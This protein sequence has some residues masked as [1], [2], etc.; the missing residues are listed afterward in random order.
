VDYDSER[1]GIAANTA[2]SAH[3]CVRVCV[4][5]V[6]VCVV[7]VCVYVRVCVDVLLICVLV[8]TVFF[9]VCTAFFVL[10]CLCILILICFLSTCVRTTVTKSQ[11]NWAVSRRHTLEARINCRFLHK[12]LEDGLNI[13]P[14]HVRLRHYTRNSI[15]FCITLVII[16]L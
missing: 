11:L 16:H 13:S 3:N 8:F 1:S 7:W 9:I 2:L 4:V 14:K 6:C 15:T 5:W 12:P 10:F